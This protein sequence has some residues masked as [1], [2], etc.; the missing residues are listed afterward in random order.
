MKS[1]LLVINFI[2]SWAFVYSQN[3]QILSKGTPSSFRGLSVVNDRVIWVSGSMGV[4]G[5]SVDSGTSWKFMTVKGFENTEFRDIEAFDEVTAIIMGIDCPAHILKTTDGGNT[6]NIV[7]KDTTKGMFLDA[8]E[9]WNDQSGI[10]I[11]DPINQH[12][13]IARTFDGGNHWQP[14]PF[15]N[16]PSAD[17][18]EA[19]FASSGTNIRKINQKEAVFVS[20]GI[21]SNLFYREIKINIP[22]IKGME[23][24]GAN[25]IAVKNKNT[26]MIVGGDFNFKDAS[27]SNIAITQNGGKKWEKSLNAP[28]GYRSCVEFI[29]QKKWITC[30]LTGVDITYDDGQNFDWISKESFNVCRRSKKGKVVYLAGN[31]G[32]I[33]KL[34]D[35]K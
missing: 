35:I 5:K 3:I 6:W 10:V 26:M 19:C 27:Q 30:G 18:G 20:G 7:F 11:G 8:M 32:K 4:V 29:N 33:A 34:I 2:C 16:R 14:L 17:P 28:H 1:I 22:V 13:F 15:S 25:S 12:F 21:T 24:T 31:N 23:S 9:F